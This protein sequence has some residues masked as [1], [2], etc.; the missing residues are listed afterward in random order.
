MNLARLGRSIHPPWIEPIEAE[1]LPRVMNT[2]LYLYEMP[3]ETFDRFDVI[4][5]YRISRTPVVAAGVKDV[6]LL[7]VEITSRGAE[8]RIVQSLWIRMRNAQPAPVI[9]SGA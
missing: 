5:G 2:A 9:A 7:P 6:H 1:W 4:A 8:V 3:V